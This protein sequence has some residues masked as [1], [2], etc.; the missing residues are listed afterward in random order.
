M[1]S[2]LQ[3]SVLAFSLAFGA[4]ITAQSFPKKNIIWQTPL[5]KE[6]GNILFNFRGSSAASASETPLFC[7]SLVANQA[8]KVS[9]TSLE[10]LRATTQE[11]KGLKG[12]ELTENPKVETHFGKGEAAI[13]LS[14]CFVPF[15]KRNG[16]IFKITGYTPVYAA[17]PE[18][19]TSAKAYKNSGQINNPFST[20]TWHKLSVAENNLVKITPQF[21]RDEGI[22]TEDVSINSI[23]I[24]GNGIGMLPES[25]AANRPV[26][27][28]EV[29]IKVVDAN[30]DGIFNANDF[31]LF[32]AESPHKW[33]YNQGSGHFVNVVNIYRDKNFYFLSVN[34]GASPAPLQQPNGSNA[35][36]QV[37]SYD[38]LANVENEKVNLVGTGRQWFGDAFEFTLS[39]NYDFSFP[40]IVAT[41]PVKLLVNTVGR[42]STGNTTMR[43]S[44]QGNTV[45]SLPIGASPTGTYPDFVTRAAQRTNF[46]A[47][48]QNVTINLNYDNAANP[49]GV[50][51]LDKIE[52]QA[53]QSLTFRN[54]SLQFRDIRSVGTGSVAQFTITNAPADLTLWRITKGTKPVEIAGNFNA[55]V[56]TFTAEADDLEEYVA[57]RGAN[58]PVPTYETEIENQ[59]L[60][61]MPVPEMVIVVH[62]NFLSAAQELAD[63]HNGEDNVQTTVVTTN[64]VYNEYG[65]GGQDITAIRDFTKDL[66]DRSVS[67]RFKYLLLFGDASYDYKDRLN[68][69]N[70]YVPVWQSA[71]SFNLGSS[72]ITDD[73]YGYM[74]VGENNNNLFTGAIL[75][76]GI[77][78]IPCET[79]TQARQYV[80]KVKNY[81]AATASYGD[82]RNRILLLADDADLE[83]EPAYFVSNGSEV[84][85]QKALN[86][87]T[88]FNIEKIYTDAYQQVSTT[89]S[90][91][92]PEASRDMFRKVQQG[93]L[94]TNYIGHGG[95]IGLASEKL[96]T[97]Q[98]VNDWT[99]FDALSLFITI[100]C[101]FTRFDDPRRVSAGEQLLL[102]PRGGAIALLTTTR[103]VGARQG[104][105]LNKS[106]FDTVLARPD[107]R[108]Q[109]L[110]DIIKSAKNVSSVINSGDKTKFSLV[111][112]PA[113][114]LAIP[115]QYVKTSSINGK[116]PAQ[117]ALDTLQALSLVNLSGIVEDIN[118]NPISDF[119]GIMQISVFDKETARETFVNDG[120]GVPQKFN[121][122]SSLIYR[123]KVAVTQG[124]FKAEFRVPLDISYRFGN[125]KISYY[126]SDIENEVDA[127]GSYDTI[128]VGG[129]NANAPADNQGP[130][131]ELFMNDRSFVRGGVTGK[132]PFLFAMLRDSS[133][134]NT[135]GN[136][137]GHDLKAVLNNEND[138]PF[139]LNEFYEADL[140][141]YKSGEVRYQFFDLE[142]GEYTLT[143][144]GFDI[145][146]N[147]S[148]ATTEFLV[149]DS[150]DLV[151][152]KLLNYP[153]PFTT[154]TEFQFEHNRANQPLDVQVQVFTV[155]GKL[156][157][158]I[159]TS[160]NTG[161]N[162]VTG[163]SWNGLDDYGD[164]IGKGVYVYRVKVRSPLDNAMADE[165]EKLVILR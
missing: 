3:L 4:T 50:A 40:D 105:D 118:G 126:G 165:Y 85:E 53:R 133:G 71:A 14:Y 18:S 87:S 79:A 41:E 100:T 62:P 153:N 1:K 135:V 32:Y 123:G 33:V 124:I 73:Y 103:V 80:A 116:D 129:F 130:F 109:T 58:F 93:C 70:N 46:N 150:E 43:A 55:G 121:V 64:Q 155:S 21:L 94:I 157:K 19:I 83:W 125:G 91:T 137:V 149:A 110:G 20:G 113:L 84:L 17:T 35:N 29:A 142:E 106:I 67:G 141:S 42:A 99:N 158:T 101:E 82:W 59:N 36:V 160:I 164:K 134:I 97:L 131:I 111:G 63:F 47:Q 54:N 138:K 9:I 26:G 144:R 24:V 140:N 69:N 139:V 65:S 49:S 145:Y 96:L 156:V 120:V 147:P 90:E 127:A 12:A 39:Y 151:L 74:D 108:P 75:D 86:A 78:R 76:L 23:R 98:H 146:N 10:L 95:E 161:G 16:Q 92:Y 119:N 37:S 34:S 143:L 22:S 132:D 44:Y 104:T 152:R 163:I 68:G 60:Q 102:N 72:Y 114:R 52:L 27:V 112:D 154:Y 13:R 56:Y 11:I 136:G 30:S 2:Y 159:N 81:S 57:F 28:E 128:V 15:V 45:L 148:E 107:G 66:Y 162:R 6:D 5:Q 115:Y 38:G 31:A 7:E 8:G 77:G 122:R 25:L 61:G 117:A 51:W 48:S 89:G 88:A